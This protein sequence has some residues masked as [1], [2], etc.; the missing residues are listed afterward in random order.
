MADLEAGFAYIWEYSVRPECVAEFEAAYG[1]D[2]DWVQLF[3][4]AEGYRR[5]ELHRDRHDSVR[6]LTIDYWDSAQAWEEFRQNLA[7]EFD[8]LDARCE[9]YTTSEHELGRLDPL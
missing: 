3:K 6:Y 7:A 9:A 8:A 5:T 2:G 4:R 1:P